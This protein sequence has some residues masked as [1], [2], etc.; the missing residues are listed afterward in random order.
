MATMAIGLCG[1]GV[2][3]TTQCI[4]I[5]APSSKYFGTFSGR[6]FTAR[7]IC[8]ADPREPAEERQAASNMVA[9]PLMPECKAAG[10]RA[11]ASASCATK[12]DERISEGQQQQ[13]AV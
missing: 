12:A 6:P 7:C 3:S 1:I 8:R 9:N 5:A 4:G 13:S 10:T 2:I 11:I